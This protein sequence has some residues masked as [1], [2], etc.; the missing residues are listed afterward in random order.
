[1]EALLETIFGLCN[2][3]SD[4]EGEEMLTVPRCEVQWLYARIKG[5]RGTKWQRLALDM[6]EQLFG[7]KCQP[8]D[9]KDGT[10]DGTKEPNVDSSK[11][12]VESLVDKVDSLEPKT[13]EPKFK[14][15]DELVWDKRILVKVDE[16][17][18]NGDYLVYSRIGNRYAVHESDLE[19]YTEPDDNHIADPGKMVDALIKDGFSKERRLNIAAMAMQGLLANPHQQMI[20][21]SID[22]TVMLAVSAADALIAEC[23]KK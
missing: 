5:F 18:A 14:V 21:M 4:A 13:A 16:I 10:M 22:D 1:M 20:D 19:P 8:D 15:G 23:E 2:L 7:S 11:P 12:N 6:L 9:T 17:L 3:T